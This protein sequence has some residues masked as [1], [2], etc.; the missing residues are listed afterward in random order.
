MKNSKGIGR[1]S[2]KAQIQPMGVPQGK[3]RDNR[4]KKLSKL[5]HKVVFWN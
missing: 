1:F 4:G 5:Q 3:K 2:Q